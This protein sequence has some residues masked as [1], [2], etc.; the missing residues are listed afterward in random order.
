ML[1]NLQCAPSDFRHTGWA[2]SYA[3]DIN[4]IQIFFHYHREIL[5]TDINK[6][7]SITQPT[8]AHYGAVDKPYPIFKLHDK[9]EEKTGW[10][11][12]ADTDRR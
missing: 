6:I 10:D 3:I 4:T 5:S 8:C 9:I 2:F 12:Y 1:S 11:G 7:S